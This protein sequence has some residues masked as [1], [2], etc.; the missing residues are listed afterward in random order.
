MPH[1][2]IR[3]AIG[4]NVIGSIAYIFVS[5]YANIVATSSRVYCIFVKSTNRNNFH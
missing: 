1:A 3:I 5:L 4:I 2:N